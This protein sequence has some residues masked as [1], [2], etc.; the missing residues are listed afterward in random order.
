MLDLLI[1]AA[2]A[3]ASTAPGPEWRPFA[4]VEGQ[5]AVFLDPTSLTRDGDTFEIRVRAVF[6]TPR[7]SGMVVGVTRIRIDCT[8]HTVALRQVTGYD[9]QGRLLSDGAAVGPA[10]EP[11][12]VPADSSYQA[13]I[14]EYCPR[15]ATTA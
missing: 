12:T 13:L 10:A 2:L 15:P 5:G 4:T 14:D 1:A 9:A 6:D 7:S 8:R 11:H 3:Q